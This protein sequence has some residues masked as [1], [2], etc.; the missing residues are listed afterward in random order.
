MFRY[1]ADKDH[2]N[3]VL[4]ASFDA[5]ELLW[6]GTSDLKDLHVKYKSVFVPYLKVL[7]EA[8]TRDVSVRIIH[9]KEPGQHFRKDFDKY[10]SVLK[11]LERMLCPRV[12]FK[13]III[14]MKWAYIGSANLTGA[15][16]GAKSPDRRNFET[17]IFTDN[18]H[19]VE[20]AM[21]QF[22]EVWMGKHCK[23]CSR[24]DFCGDGIV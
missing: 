17:G 23:T 22:D 24:K 7:S 21:Q 3:E 8:L 20:S 14:D 6:I 12:H 16:M 9:A 1:I 4:K 5:E 10:P 13:L 19:I 15:G 11:N 2:Y 18:R